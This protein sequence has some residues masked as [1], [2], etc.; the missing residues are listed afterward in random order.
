MRILKKNWEI[1]DVPYRMGNKMLSP[2]E[3][4]ALELVD[5]SVKYDGKR[6]EVGIPWKRHPDTLALSNYNEAER[7][8]FQIEKQLIKKPEIHQAYEET[9]Q[10]YLDKGY[11]KQIENKK[12]GFYLAH[13][14]VVRTDKD[15][16]KTRIV[17]D[18][19]AK[20]DGVL[21]NDLIY[22]GPKLQKDMFDVLLRFRR[23]V[24][25]VVCDISEMYLQ[26]K[27]QPEDCKYLL[28]LWRNM[29]QSKEPCCYQFQR[30]VFG[31]NSA[32]FEAQYIAQKNAERHKEKFP[33]A[34][35]TILQSTYMDDSMD[36]VANEDD[37][38]KLVKQLKQ[39]WGKAGMYPRKW[40]SNSKNVL[41]EIDLQDR[42]KQIDLSLDDLPSVK[43]LGVMWS[44][45]SDEFSFCKTI[46]EE[47]A[48]LTKRKFLSKISTLFDP[49]G[50]LTPFT[51]RAKIL[52][53]EI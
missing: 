37:A 31:L 13:F 48:V 10:Q 8:L 35:E 47:S 26:I 16:T 9:I 7:R 4:Q 2:E 3:K 41:E 51:V 43:T 23:N 40:L 33:L 14:P 19:A 27:V 32:P 38:I 52:M 39:L 29:D 20:K 45:S 24:V 25:A 21:I 49:L 36:S 15:T 17:F 5:E 12:T 6:Y 28:F 53:Q 50:F 11:I 42:A 34:Y 1:E 18:V 44:A 46:L 22:A 30:L